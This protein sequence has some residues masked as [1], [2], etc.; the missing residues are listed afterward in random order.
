MTD[1]TLK[2]WSIPETTAELSKKQEPA[3]KPVPGLLLL[4]A[5]DPDIWDLY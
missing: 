4:Q 3:P 2:K 1:F 5:R